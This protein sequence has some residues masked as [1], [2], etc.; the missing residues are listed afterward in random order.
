MDRHISMVDNTDYQKRII[1]TVGYEGSIL[2]N[3]INYSGTYLFFSFDLVNSTSFKNKQKSWGKIFNQFFNYC[4]IEMKSSFDNIHA[5]K[6]I[7]DEILFY[8]PIL[9]MDELYSTPE[10]TSLVLNKCIEFIDGLPEAKSLL[11]VKATL[12]AA[13][14]F[15]S[16][17]R[18][19]SKYS[20]IIIKERTYDTVQL[21]F[22][23]PDIDIGFRISKYAL[24]SI[25]VIDAKL[26]CLL[27]KLKTELSKDHISNYMRIVS[28]EQLKGVWGNRYYPIVWY[29][30]EWT[31]FEN[32]FTYDQK[33][34]SDIVLRIEE[35]KGESLE[36]VSRLTK[37]FLDLNKFDEIDALSEGIEF[38]KKN[39]PL[40]KIT[41]QIPRDKLS[42]LHVVAICFNNKSEI[43]IAKRTNKDTLP[44]NW[45][46]G[47]SQLHINQDFKTAL[48]EG[49][50]CD[51][52]IEID[53]FESEPLPIGT[54]TFIKEKENNRVVPGIIFVCKIISHEEDIKLD[55][56]KHSAY[57]WINKENY[58][59]LL[60]ENTVSDFEK[61][62]LMA[63]KYLDV[64]NKS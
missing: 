57:R 51:F 6:M 34:N 53:F 12:W 56:S 64:L 59:E 42:E 2:S 35:T 41:K 24:E 36:S 16:E 44:N 29:Q 4:S 20:N 1:A 17:E 52:G 43:L 49:Y 63:Y 22:L 32:M 60:Q 33:F 62:I 11:S 10:K 14:V 23:G 13:V 45:E 15:D 37:I 31:Y 27:T 30:K 54:Y 21:D 50:K 55:A 40:E 9:S 47:C 18:D 28:Y 39:N 25:L 48:K 5:W 46:F 8:L 3:D 61:R 19:T 26:A 38:Y 7:G 58:K